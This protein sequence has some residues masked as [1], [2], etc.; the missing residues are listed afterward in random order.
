MEE[1]D[2]I[3]ED[4]GPLAST[5]QEERDTGETSRGIGSIDIIR[6][7]GRD[8][9]EHIQESLSKATG[10]AFVTVDYKGEPVTDM[11]FFS[12]FC[13]KFR[14]DKELRQNCRTSDAMGSIQAAVTKKTHIYFCRCGLI[15]M[16]IPIV[17]EG[18]YLGGFLGGQFR[19]EDAPETVRQIEPTVETE[20]FRRLREES[21]QRF[22]ELPVY[23]YEKILDMANL[24][25]L[26]ITQ[27]SENRANQYYQ[28]DMLKKRI[29]KIQETNQKHL[30]EKA[31]LEVRFHEL[32]A[33]SNPYSY[34]NMLIA[35]QNLGTV[36]QA[37]RTT[38]LAD[39]F[40][41]H[42]KYGI[43]DKGTFVHFAGELEYVEQ[44][45]KFQKIRLGSQFNYTL[46]FPREMQMMKLPAGVL[47][48]FVQ[49]AFYHGVMLSPEGG[50]ISLNGYLKQGNF[51]LE[52]INTGS[53]FSNEELKIR[54]E[55]YK[56]NH[57]GYY[58]QLGMECAKRKLAQLFGDEYTITVEI[59]KNKG[60][61][62]EIIFPEYK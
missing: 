49:N 39:L 34:L 45:L 17:V 19:C 43:A 29:K 27:L 8:K 6:L 40:I 12:D 36:E 23:S 21:R 48:P 24:V 53:G 9:L 25:S 51:V 3:F 31:E 59:N 61:R 14:E 37:E 50:S 55:P 1:L 60:C 13:R 56:N 5:D 52:I 22:E 11:T 16:A 7:F 10:L 15:E 47:F 2:R 35:L 38:E 42:V 28:E 33:Q 54:F 32:E 18:N 4:T 20:R 46:H 57:E 26:V 44:Y 62:C 30:K 41:S 58:I